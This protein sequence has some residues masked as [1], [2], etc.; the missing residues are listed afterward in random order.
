MKVL[1]IVLNQIDKLDRIL[2]DL[3]DIGVKGATILQSSGMAKA[4]RDHTL[5]SNIIGSLRLFLNSEREES[6]TIF[7]VVEEGLVENI[8]SVVKK[9]IDLS[10]PNTGIMFCLP[11]DF[12][13]GIR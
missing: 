7:M 4:L 9:N 11:I 12:V 3:N 8:K 6:R 2:G 5:E 10:L 1:F 13:E